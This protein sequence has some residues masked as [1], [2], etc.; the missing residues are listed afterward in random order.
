MISCSHW[1]MFEGAT[2]GL[3]AAKLAMGRIGKERPELIMP[4][5]ASSVIPGRSPFDHIT[6]D[7]LRDLFKRARITFDV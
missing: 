2:A 4:R 5:P 3:E 1:G 6:I 7:Q